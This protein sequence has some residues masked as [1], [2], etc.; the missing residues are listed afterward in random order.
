M[1]HW[2]TALQPVCSHRTEEQRQSAYY[3]VGAH[4]VTHWYTSVRLAVWPHV[5]LHAAQSA[6]DATCNPAAWMRLTANACSAQVWIVSYLYRRRLRSK[7]D[8][9][10][11][12]ASSNVITASKP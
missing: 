6:C 1:T 11:D 5:Q 8:V 12:V 4:D 10:A 9:P 7:S 3:M 2:Y